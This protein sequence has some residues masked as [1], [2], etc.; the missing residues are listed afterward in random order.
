MIYTKEWAFIHIPKTAGLN[1]IKRIEHKLGV[2]NG[3][4][5]LQKVK[6]VVDEDELDWI[7]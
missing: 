5:D 3:H 4:K 1:F 6:P 2:I 7:E